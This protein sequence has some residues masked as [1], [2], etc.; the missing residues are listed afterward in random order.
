MYH[1]TSTQTMRKWRAPS[2]GRLCWPAPSAFHDCRAPLGHLSSPVSSYSQVHPSN[3]LQLHDSFKFQIR[4]IPDGIEIS[5]HLLPAPDSKLEHPKELTPMDVRQ[6]RWRLEEFR[7]VLGDDG[8]S[9]WVSFNRTS[10]RTRWIA[11]TAK[12]VQPLWHHHAFP[13][14][15]PSAPLAVF[16]TCHLRANALDESQGRKVEIRVET[17]DRAISC[18]MAKL[19]VA[20]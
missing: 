7:S 20:M 6:F 13:A 12:H 4:I 1:S 17:R 16:E 19:T 15:V 9:T 3:L 2:R 11:T 8:A 10:N 18:P 5:L 14:F